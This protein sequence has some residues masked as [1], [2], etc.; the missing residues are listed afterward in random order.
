MLKIFDF[1]R[2]LCEQ[3]NLSFALC[4]EYKIE[5]Y[6]LQM[7]ND[8]CKEK[9]GVRYVGLNKMFMSTTNCE[10]IDI[11]IYGRKSLNEK[12]YPLTDC[13]GKCL[14]C[15]DAK[16]GIQDLAQGFKGP[17]GFKLKDYKNFG[18]MVRQYSLF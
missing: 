16:C 8:K 18:N 12:F 1:L 6:K 15:K 9:T 10:G 13:N 3:Q 14:T 7:I 17:K 5:S 11:P 2:N 4:M